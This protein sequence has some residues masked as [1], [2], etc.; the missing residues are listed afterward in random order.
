MYTYGT[1]PAHFVGSVLRQDGW[2]KETGTFRKKLV[3]NAYLLSLVFEQLYRTAVVIG[4][5]SPEIALQLLTDIKTWD[6]S[7]V[8]EF[9]AE[10]DPH[11]EIVESLPNLPWV[12]LNVGAIKPKSKRELEENWQWKELWD[13]KTVAIFSFGYLQALTWSL[14]HPV[15]AKEQLTREVDELGV[16]FNQATNAGYEGVEPHTSISELYSDIIMTVET[17][18]QTNGELPDIEPSLLA[19]AK[20]CQISVSGAE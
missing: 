16:K 13:E 5:Q 17:Y 6:G 8:D 1:F 9:I 4:V 18:I 3:V 2:P 15:E 19:H 14:L 20:F 7:S 10:V 12:T 11:A